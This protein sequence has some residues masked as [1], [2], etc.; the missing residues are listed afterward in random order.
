MTNRR[1]NDCKFE[2]RDLTDVAQ[3]RRSVQDAADRTRQ[4]LSQLDQDPMIALF[5]L[6][7]EGYGHNPLKN[8]HQSLREQIYRT[9]TIMAIL[10][11]ADHIFQKSPVGRLCLK[12]AEDFLGPSSMALRG[13]EAPEI[14]SIETDRLEA[15]VFAATTY[16]SSTS[17]NDV[18]RRRFQLLAGSSAEIRLIY[19]YW[20]HVRS[21]F[22]RSRYN[23]NVESDPREEQWR[24]K[25]LERQREQELR[26]KIEIEPADGL[27]DKL[28]RERL[29]MLG[30][31]R[32]RE[33]GIPRE[34]PLTDR[35]ERAAGRGIE[36]WSLPLL[37]MIL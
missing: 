6:H 18:L 3:F 25:D 19:F 12:L 29:E 21:E 35:E 17:S 14:R 33:L 16:P 23:P 24:L 5:Q 2:V 30:A 32:L 10:A 28:Y 8:R 36:I 9:F 22:Q 31:R 4:S 34:E 27:G 7:F 20:P 15:R 37:K 26:G 13:S 1:V 11:A